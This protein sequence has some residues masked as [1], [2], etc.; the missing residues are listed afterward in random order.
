MQS[1]ISTV[2]NN[3]AP[4]GYQIEINWILGALGIVMALPIWRALAAAWKSLWMDRVERIRALE[5]QITCDQ[6]EFRKHLESELVV[7]RVLAQTQAETISAQQRRISDLVRQVEEA[8]RESS[9][10]RQ[11]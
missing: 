10:L 8:Q 9:L 5:L 3:P 1:T 2:E 11:A 6:A 7:L 4:H